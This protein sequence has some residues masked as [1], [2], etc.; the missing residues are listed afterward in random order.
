MI[1]TDISPASIQRSP[2]TASPDRPD[3]ARPADPSCGLETTKDSDDHKPTMRE[4]GSEPIVQAAVVPSKPADDRTI[5][6]HEDCKEDAD[7]LVL[8]L[9]TLSGKRRRIVC[10]KEERVADV[11]RRVWEDWPEGTSRPPRT[12]YALLTL[13]ATGPR[14]IGPANP[15]N[16]KS[17]ISSLC[18]CCSP[19]P[20]TG[21]RGRADLTDC[22]LYRGRILP[23]KETLSCEELQHL[24][25]PLEANGGAHATAAG[26]KSP[27]GEGPEPIVVH[28]H[29]R[30]LPP[31]PPDERTYTRDFSNAGC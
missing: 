29:V 24:D 25:L 14:Q 27:E 19:R 28:L 30:T 23:G 5:V 8:Q 2:A 11:T 10:R 26:V 22:R 20:H 6:H 7:D 13:F 9:L 1:G 17:R 4:T 12:D 15:L 31:L 18:T 3:L 16:Q 21:E